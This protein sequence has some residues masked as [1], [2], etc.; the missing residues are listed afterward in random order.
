MKITNYTH[1]SL[2]VILLAFLSFACQNEFES[3]TNNDFQINNDSD[4]LSKRLSL[5]G[6]G[7]IGITAPVNPSG[8]TLD[9]EEAEKITLQ[10]ISQANSPIFKDNILQA[11]HVDINGDYAYVSYNTAGPTYLGGVDIIS[12]ADPFKPKI[13]SQILFENADISAVEFRDGVLYMAMAMDVDQSNASE[14]ANLGSVSVINGQFAS[15]F[16]YVSLPGFVATD[17]STNDNLIAVVSGNNGVLAIF[18]KNLQKLNEL[19]QVD[20]RSISMEN[21]RIAILSGIGEVKILNTN[22]LSESSSIQLNPDESGAKRTIDIN[23]DRVFVSEGKN[24]AGIYQLTNGNLIQKLP[25]P[26]K[27]NDV[28]PGEIVTNAVTVDNGLLLMANGAA[29]VSLTNV[30]NEIEDFGILD[31]DGSSNFVR[32]EDDFVFV[33]SGSGGLQILKI[34]RPETNPVASSC[35]GL[36]TYKGN[37]NLNVNS[38]ENKSYSGSAQFK[39]V[40]IGGNFLFCGSLAIEQNLNINS[41]GLMEVNG[42]FAFGQYRKNTSLNIN[43]NSILRLSG[44]T[45]IYGDLRLNSGAKLEFVGEGNSITIFGD[46]TINSGAS[47]TGNF[48]D[49]EGK[50]N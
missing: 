1:K 6:T 24:G 11:T 4:E 39:N 41:N 45:V 29:G 32:Y 49:T 44:S 47:I 34:D 31:L 46:V 25:I 8:R 15:D 17:V 14:P 40:N 16:R 9:D 10:L 7:I 5:E 36:E 3:P 2:T 13:T 50:L 19:P 38:N 30:N 28:A 23:T 26:I 22:S 43:S 33:A 27:P 18:D 37:S 48:T 35:E 12:I 20:L 42:S 21:D